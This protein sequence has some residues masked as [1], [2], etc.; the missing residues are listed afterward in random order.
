MPTDAR[1]TRAASKQARDNQDSPDAADHQSRE[2]STVE[3]EEIEVSRALYLASLR[4]QVQ[5]KKEAQEIERLE[6][7][8]RDE[9]DLD[10]KPIIRTQNIKVRGLSEYRGKTIKEA[11]DWFL[12]AENAFSLDA[13]TFSQEEIKIRW[14]MQFPSAQVKSLWNSHIQIRPLEDHAWEDLK[15]FLLDSIEHPANRMANAYIRWNS[16]RQRDNQSVA[17]F[18]NYLQ[19]LEQQIEEQTPLASAMNFFAKL[20]DKIQTQILNSAQDLPNTREAMLTLAIRMEGNPK[21]RGSSP[22]PGQYFKKTRSDSPATDKTLPI[23]NRNAAGAPDRSKCGRCG[24]KNHST[25]DC[26]AKS[27]VNNTPLGVSR[28]TERE[29]QGAQRPS[30]GKE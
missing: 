16:F 2:T 5:A 22:R 9:G 19:A 13:A 7:Y 1:M 30:Q 20:N 12:E 28:L 4:R 8:L 24:R 18:N 15:T 3:E 10:A 29:A 17:D 23:R 25:K 11:R 14:A 27:D 21:R 6:A 26:F